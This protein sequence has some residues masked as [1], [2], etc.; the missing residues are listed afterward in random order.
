[1][2]ALE[3]GTEGIAFSSGAAATAMLAELA[4]PGDEV[5]IGDDVYGGTYRLFERVLRPKGIVARYVDLAGDPANVRSALSARTRLVW[6]ET[7]TNPLLKLVDIAGVVDALTGHQ[8]AEGERAAASSSTTRSLRRPSSVRSITA[9]T[10]CSTRRR[11]IS[12]A[13]RTRSTGSSSPAGRRW[14][15]GCASCRT[16]SAPSRPVRL[17]PRPARTAHAGPADRAPCGQRGGRGRPAGCPRGRRARCAIPA[18][19]PAPMLIPRR[20]LPL[21]RCGTPAG[22]SRSCPRAGGAHGRTSE[23]RAPGDLRGDPPVHPGRV[24]R[25]GRVADRAAG[26][27]DPCLGRRLAPRGRSGASSGCRAG[28]RARGTS[29][30]TCRPRSRRPDGGTA[31]GSLEA[32]ASERRDI[33]PTVSGTVR[34]A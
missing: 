30:R 3:G 4:L 28:S 21:A 12:A 26:D 32:R 25:R 23:Q 8:G 5:V 14:P 20:A 6:F 18:S 31:W 11:S 1:M 15:S 13:T 10:S 16:R 34:T 7:P 17:L 29:W 2:A 19:H 33:S 24:A 27:D 9:P 22:W